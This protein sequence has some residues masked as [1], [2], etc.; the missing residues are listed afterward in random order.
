MRLVS[1]ENYNSFLVLSSTPLAMG[2]GA[3]GCSFACAYSDTQ[4]IKSTA[5]MGPLSF[6][7]VSDKKMKADC[8]PANR[9]EATER[10]N[11][12]FF[13]CSAKS[14]SK[15]T[16]NPN[17][18]VR[19]TYQVTLHPH[20]THI[21][22]RS[23]IVQTQFC[24]Y[25]EQ[26]PPVHGTQTTRYPTTEVELTAPHCETDVPPQVTSRHEQRQPESRRST[27]SGWYA[28]CPVPSCHLAPTGQYKT[29]LRAA[30]ITLPFHPPPHPPSAIPS[31][32][33]KS[34]STLTYGW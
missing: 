29:H 27:A 30:S 11:E 23:T 17:R 31:Q 3:E 2:D 26:K 21:K 7:G 34:R 33:C 6:V 1:H 19:G 16:V 18:Q 22:E 20:A 5:Y 13:V 24:R 28:L 12:C 9:I 8:V 25:K 14:K 10:A 4:R 15:R 32:P